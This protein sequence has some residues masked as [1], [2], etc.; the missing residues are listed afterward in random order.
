MDPISEDAVFEAVRAAGEAGEYTDWIPA[1]RAQA[2][3]ADRPS[4]GDESWVI[5]LGHMT[6]VPPES[7]PVSPTDIGN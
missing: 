7:A 4:L 2:G 3:A 6:T 5:P 1:L